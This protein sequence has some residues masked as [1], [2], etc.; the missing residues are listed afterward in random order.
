MPTKTAN[1]PTPLSIPH[2]RQWPKRAIVITQHARA[3]HARRDRLTRLTLPDVNALCTDLRQI[4]IVMATVAERLDRSHPAAD[5]A[6]QQINTESVQLAEAYNTLIDLA[7]HLH[8]AAIL[9][10][11]FPK[12][13]RE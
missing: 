8:R 2:R 6:W 3:V 10:N 9:A 11:A 5:L 12:E 4:L 1:D 7:P 13:A